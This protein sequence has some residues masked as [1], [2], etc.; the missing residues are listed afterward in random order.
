[1]VGPVARDYP[2]LMPF[3]GDIDD[4]FELWSAELGDL[5][6]SW[7]LTN[8][9]FGAGARPGS[10]ASH[11]DAVLE[12]S[13]PKPYKP[14][15]LGAGI[16]AVQMIDAAAQHLNGLRALVHSRAMALAPWP[17]ARAICEHVAHAVWLLEPDI[18]P[19]ARM[20][21]RWMAR[22]AGAQRLRFLAR[23]GSKPQQR[24]A[25]EIRDSIREQ[26]LLRFPDTDVEWND[27]AEHPL[28]P[29]QIAGESY[30]T[31]GQ[32]TRL[33]SKFGAINVASL[34]DT[35][36]LSS[37]PNI[38]TLTMAVE[39]VDAGGYL[40]MNYRT[41]PEDWSATIQLAGDLLH[42]A[43]NAACGYLHGQTDHLTDWYHRY[44]TQPQ[45][46]GAATDTDTSVP[47]V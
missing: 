12:A 39:P 5:Y 21:R 47:T 45:P 13:S 37:H 35:L 15:G 18:A 41:D 2:G 1:M 38:I 16:D 22:L 9:Q 4:L 24:A 28:P 44:R 17:I 43:A 34:Y 8:V 6:S 42:V 3:D 14:E 23:N 31:F 26:L 7:N 36:S 32:Q 46:A 29:W 10:P 11:D 19:E 33:L 20:A 25:K 30:P 40:K 27:P